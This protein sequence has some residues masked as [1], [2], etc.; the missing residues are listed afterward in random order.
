MIRRSVQEWRT[1]TV[2]RF[3]KHSPAVRWLDKLAR[4]NRE[5]PGQIVEDTDTRVI[6][7][8]EQ[9]DARELDV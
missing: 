3:G 7:I 9:L 8:L 1:Y 5:G 4:K 2:K 6:C